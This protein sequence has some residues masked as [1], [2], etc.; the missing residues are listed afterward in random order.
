MI[1]LTSVGMASQL[2]AAESGKA[3]RE[4]SNTTVRLAIFCAWH[5]HDLGN[6]IC[7]STSH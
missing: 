1:F 4:G 5:Q 7:G 2:S 6:L 3:A